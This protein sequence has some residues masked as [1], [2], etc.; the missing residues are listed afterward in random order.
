[1]GVTLMLKPAYPMGRAPS[2]HC[3]GVWVGFI[4]VPGA[5]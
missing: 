4:A 5:V 2:V 1:M 3:V